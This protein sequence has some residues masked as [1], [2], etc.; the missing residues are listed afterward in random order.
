MNQATQAVAVSQ[1]RGI[2]TGTRVF[3][4][5]VEARPPQVHQGKVEMLWSDDTATIKWDDNRLNT[6]RDRHL[7]QSGR[8]NIHHV[9]KINA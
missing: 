2:A 4:Q 1:L 9:S 6:E 8:V 5:D 3:V 7:V